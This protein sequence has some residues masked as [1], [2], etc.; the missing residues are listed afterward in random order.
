MAMPT[1]AKS[2]TATQAQAQTPRLCLRQLRNGDEAKP[3]L[4][5]RSL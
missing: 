5:D 1:A 2:T 3:T 4:G